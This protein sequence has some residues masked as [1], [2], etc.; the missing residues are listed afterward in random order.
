M[1]KLYF[2]LQFSLIKLSIAFAQQ[3]AQFSLYMLNPYSAN[4]AATVSKQSLVVTAGFRAQWVGLQGSPQ[5]QFVTATLPLSIISSGVGLAIE[6]ESIGARRGLSAKLSYN[7]IKRLGDAQLSVG[8]AGGIVQGTLDGSKLRTPNGDYNQ[9]VID[10]QDRLL[11]SASL[12]GIVP[13]FD[14]GI[15]FKH[16]KFEAS[17][18]SGNLTEPTLS[19]ENQKVVG[20]K[21]K[22]HYS[23]FATTH[24]DLSKNLILYPSVMVRSD[25]VQTQME[26][27]TFAR[28]NDNFFLGGSFRGFSKTTQDAA[29]IFGGLALNPKLTLA[30][31]YDITISRLKLATQ[32]SH[33]IVLQYNLGKEFGKGKLPPII[34]NPRF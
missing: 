6:N 9:G 22:K 10:H 7:Y 5:T 34:Y 29:T 32:G 11:N 26:F 14:A 18:A 31:A 1:K 12:T 19:L 15:Y 25:V 20:V 17:I 8:I 30:Y 2:F 28:Y 16:E 4:P 23:A 21:L 24:F 3:P 27:S 13:T 33:E